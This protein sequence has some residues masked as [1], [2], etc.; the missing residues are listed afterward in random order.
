MSV[1]SLGIAGLCLALLVNI[2]SLLTGAF[3]LEN[4]SYILFFIFAILLKFSGRRFFN[5]AFYL[6]TGFTVAS[7]VLKYVDTQFFS[8]EFSMVLL[9]MA[10]TV[11]IIE[12]LKYIVIKNG[13]YL[14]LLYFFGIVG[15]NGCL[16]GYHLVELQE[17]IS[18]YIAYSVYILYYF[19]LLLLGIVSFIYY[20]NSY[21]KRSMFFVSLAL[22]LIFA[23]VLRDMGC[24]T[25]GI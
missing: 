25:S 22:G 15:L 21:S 12:G 20:L 19:I 17:Y 8:R 5:I 1:R 13:S 3:W 2:W 6:F 10:Y 9:S 7:Y 11:L 24:F 14:M 23:D 4:T 16:L 18:G